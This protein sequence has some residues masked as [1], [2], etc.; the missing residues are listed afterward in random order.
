MEEALKKA[1]KAALQEL[2]RLL[3]G[4]AKN[5]QALSLGLECAEKNEW[6]PYGSSQPC[7][8]FDIHDLY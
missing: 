3:N 8:E 2:S 4:D 1:V 5:E 6:L 7:I